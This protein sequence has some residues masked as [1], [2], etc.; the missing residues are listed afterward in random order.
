MDAFIL[1]LYWTFVD[2]GFASC[3]LDETSGGAY[4]CVSLGASMCDE[5]F[6]SGFLVSFL[7]Y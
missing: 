5:G 7:D 2:G 3:F 6:F 4:F 1:G